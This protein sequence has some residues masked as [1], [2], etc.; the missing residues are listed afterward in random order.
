MMVSKVTTELRVPWH[1]EVPVEDNA[2]LKSM[3]E[4]ERFSKIE[5]EL[6]VK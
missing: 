3:F 5:I 1:G 4:W 6:L 2:M